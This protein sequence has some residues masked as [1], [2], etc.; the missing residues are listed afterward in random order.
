ML[1]GL[2]MVVLLLCAARS[3]PPAA[4]SA[5]GAPL[6]AAARGDASEVGRLLAVGASVTVRDTEGRT[7]LL[8]L[9]RE[10]RARLS[11]LTLREALKSVA[12]R[13]R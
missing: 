8:A 6:A 3:A 1:R 11:P 7:A 4:P 2:P 10:Y 12:R 5:D 13:G 9:C